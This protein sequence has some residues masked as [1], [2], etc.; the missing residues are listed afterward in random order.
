MLGK[1]MRRPG[2]TYV[3]KYDKLFVRLIYFLKGIA[4]RSI[5]TD[6]FPLPDAIF[7]CLSFLFLSIVTFIFSPVRHSVHPVLYFFSLSRI[8]LPVSPSSTPFDEH[9][10]NLLCIGFERVE[11]AT[12]DFRYDPLDRSH[13]VCKDRV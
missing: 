3:I 2:I 4:V 12:R 7:S 13:C 9:L 6:P 1:K 11:L 8:C 10:H 5:V